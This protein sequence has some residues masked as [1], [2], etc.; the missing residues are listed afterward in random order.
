MFYCIGPCKSIAYS[1]YTRNFLKGFK[2]KLFKV[3]L[4]VWACTLKFFMGV[5][6]S[7]NIRKKII[8]AS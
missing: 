2:Q 8:M 3:D 6:G 7:G 4:K 5:K 1:L